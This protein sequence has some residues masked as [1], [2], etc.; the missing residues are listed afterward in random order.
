MGVY[1]RYKRSPEGFRALVELMEAA[2]VAR[3]QKMIDVGMAEDPDF[4]LKTM[5]YMMNFE[6]IV[7]LPDLELAEVMAAAPPRL[8][9][10]AIAQEPLEVKERFLRNA[11]PAVR[12][13]VGDF[14]KSEITPREIGGAR[15]KVIEVARKLERQGLV[16]TKIIPD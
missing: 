13:E 1:A 12:A 11:M 6:D 16:R 4:T 9:A 10:F 14:L 15:L 2:P 7:K 3:R 5:R 8:T